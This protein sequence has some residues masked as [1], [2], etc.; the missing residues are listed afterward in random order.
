M[1]NYAK[2]FKQKHVLSLRRDGSR[3]STCAHARGRRRDQ[4]AEGD[5][6]TDSIAID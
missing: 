3:P 5:R 2:N 1:Y 4:H 6:E